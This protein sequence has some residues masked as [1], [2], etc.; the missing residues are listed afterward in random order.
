MHL[1]A[2]PFNLGMLHS[3]YFNAEFVQLSVFLKY[4]FHTRCCCLICS[5]HPSLNQQVNSWQHR[6][7]RKTL[8]H[9]EQQWLAVNKIKKLCHPVGGSLGEIRYR[10]RNR[11]TKESSWETPR[12]LFWIKSVLFPYLYHAWNSQSFLRTRKLSELKHSWMS[13]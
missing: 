12:F 6:I 4:L 3:I 7:Q 5:E 1:H 8:F 10:A 9:P 11:R 2:S 13:L